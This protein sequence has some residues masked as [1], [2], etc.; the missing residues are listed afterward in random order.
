[1]PSFIFNSCLR[2]EKL[3]D[4][5]F[6][7]DTFKAMLVTSAYNPSKT[8][9]SKRSDVTDEVVGV[10]YAPGGVVVTASVSSSIVTGF[11]DVTFEN[12][13]WVGSTITSRGCVIYKSRGGA[14]SADELVAYVDF[15]DDIVTNSEPF[16]VTFSTPLRYQN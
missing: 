15:G 6:A 14:S 4:I 1:M 13:T 7:D 5:V 2:D 3:G 16:I 8:T 12:P 10:G 9:H 11:T